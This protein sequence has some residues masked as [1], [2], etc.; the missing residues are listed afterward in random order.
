MELEM[1]RYVPLARRFST[2]YDCA[3]LGFCEEVGSGLW[4]IRT[5]NGVNPETDNFANVAKI[6]RNS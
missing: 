4:E 2:V 6:S 5:R 1:Y 3:C